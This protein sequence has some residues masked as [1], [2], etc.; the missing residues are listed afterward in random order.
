LFDV[1][2]ENLGFA[3]RYGALVWHLYLS[4]WNSWYSRKLEH[5]R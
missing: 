1:C 2:A 4:D 3:L 5:A